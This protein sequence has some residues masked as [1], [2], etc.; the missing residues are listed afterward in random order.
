MVRT[1]AD[2]VTESHETEVLGVLA[3]ERKTINALKNAGGEKGR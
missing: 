3:A 2:P 1:L